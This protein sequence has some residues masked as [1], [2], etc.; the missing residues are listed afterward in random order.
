MSDNWIRHRK[1]RAKRL[2]I[3]LVAVIP[4]IEPGSFF[5]PIASLEGICDDVRNQRRQMIANHL[6]RY[7]GETDS[8]FKGINDEHAGTNLLRG[9]AIAVNESPPSLGRHR[10]C[11]R[12]IADFQTDGK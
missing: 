3:T 12:T 6:L 9:S 5:I 2:A 4:N 11:S 7:G 1:N 8:F 10:T